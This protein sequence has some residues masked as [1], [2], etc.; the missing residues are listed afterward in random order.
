M[1]KRI[2]RISLSLKNSDCY[3]TI[4]I[5]GRKPILKLNA[6]YSRIDELDEV[7]IYA[8]RVKQ[9]SISYAL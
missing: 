1:R 2:L 6:K 3:F 4:I 9:L 5:H 7:V 8:V